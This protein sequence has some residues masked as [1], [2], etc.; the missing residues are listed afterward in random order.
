MNKAY[1]LIGGN[2]GD[3]AEALNQARQAIGSRAGTLVKKSGV[4]ETAAWGKTD[5]PPFL[6]Q[7]LLLHTTHTPA[8]L[9]NLL[10]DIE[11]SMGRERREK[12]GPR[13]IDIDILLFNQLVFRS[14]ELSIPHPEMANRRFVLAPLAEIA[15]RYRHPVR[16]QTIASLLKCCADSLPV[17]R[18]PDFSTK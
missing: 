11:R 9:L 10:L 3:R 8:E 14:P 15:G 5:Q 2:M 6:N 4:Y 18:L 1:L 13:Y 16:Q 12:F 7:C 17:Q